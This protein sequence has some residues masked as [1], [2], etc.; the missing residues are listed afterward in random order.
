MLE[1]FLLGGVLAEPG[2]GARPPGDGGAGPAAGFRFPGEGLDVGA[3]DREQRQ[4]PGAAP[5]GGL[6]QV[7]GVGLAGQ[8]A[9]PARNPASASRAGS[10]NTGWTG[11]REVEA[12]AVAIRAPPGTARAWKAGPPQVP[13]MN[14]ARNV[15]RPPKTSYATIRS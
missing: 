9:Y 1:E 7:E 12:V 15:C 13:A 3:A 4:G 14:D 11:T 5:A 10:V 2:D 8:A 6:P